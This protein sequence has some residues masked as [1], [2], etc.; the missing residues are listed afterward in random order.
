MPNANRPSVLGD[1]APDVKLLNRNTRALAREDTAAVAERLQAHGV[2]GACDQVGPKGAVVAE[3]P[4]G[5]APQR[6]RAI[7]LE[8]V[9]APGALVPARQHEMRVIGGVVEVQVGEEDVADGDRI[10]AGSR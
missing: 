9:T 5:H 2:V 6:T 3:Q 4:L 1:D 8:I 10:D 7:D